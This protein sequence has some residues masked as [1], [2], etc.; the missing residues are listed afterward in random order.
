MTRNEIRAF[1]EKLSPEMQDLYDS[2]LNAFVGMRDYA[3]LPDVPAINDEI[4]D[5]IRF[6]IDCVEKEASLEDRFD[7]IGHGAFKE[8]YDL[9]NLLGE[10]YVMKLASLANNNLGE[11]ALMEVAK[12]RGL[13]IFPRTWFITLP[14]SLPMNALW[15]EY[16]DSLQE[17]RKKVYTDWTPRSDGRPYYTWTATIPDD[18]NNDDRVNGNVLIFQ[19]RCTPMS[20]IMPYSD[21]YLPSDF[22]IS[23]DN[24]EFD[25]DACNNSYINSRKWLEIYAEGHSGQAIQDLFTFIQ[26]YDISDLRA[27][28]I[29]MTEDD[30]PV[31]MDCLS[32]A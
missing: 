31:I 22:Y 17:W 5:C 8:C 23:K 6:I 16:S 14:R 28:N 1:Y 3:S 13:D 21:M 11:K 20:A 29:G 19:E 12:S 30:R 32:R 25:Y 9:S 15:E 10:K 4:D 24:F 18:A 27:D 7:F 26:D 2:L